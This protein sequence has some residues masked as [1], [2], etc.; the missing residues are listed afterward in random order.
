MVD[1]DIRGVELTGGDKWYVELT[2]LTFEEK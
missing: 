2:G 1:L